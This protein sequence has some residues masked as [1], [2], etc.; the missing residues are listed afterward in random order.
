MRAFDVRFLSFSLCVVVFKI[1]RIQNCALVERYGRAVVERLSEVRTGFWRKV[2]GKTVD[3]IY[4]ER[5]AH[6]LTLFHGTSVPNV[7]AIAKEGFKPRCVVC[8]LVFLCVC[9]E[10]LL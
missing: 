9:S 7:D 8:W 10:S 4:N 5:N 6:E 1:E 2:A 3:W